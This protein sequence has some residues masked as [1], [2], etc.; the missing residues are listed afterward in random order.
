MQAASRQQRVT[1]LPPVV[2]ITGDDQRFPGRD[3]VADGCAQKLQ[4]A[5]A[6]AFAQSK[7]HADRVQAL[8]VSGH[9]RG[10]APLFS[11]NRSD[12]GANA[13][14]SMVMKPARPTPTR[15]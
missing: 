10:Y 12:C 7:M 14:G 5:T 3:L 15:R 6:M 1:T 9:L 11:W 13:C 2:E 8:V 4:L